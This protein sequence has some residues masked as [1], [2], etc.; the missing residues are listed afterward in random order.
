MTFVAYGIFWGFSKPKL[1]DGLHFGELIGCKLM[2]NKYNL[3]DHI[4]IPFESFAQKH[5]KYKSW[6]KYPK[7]FN[8][9]S[10]WFKTLMPLYNLMKSK[11]MGQEEKMG[12]FV[13]GVVFTHQDGRMAKLRKDM[14]PWFVG[15]SHKKF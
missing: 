2:K 1:P 13:E 8:S 5:L 11:D 6:G 4:W 7:D 12:Q 14:F 10:Q 15:V 9:I 3:D